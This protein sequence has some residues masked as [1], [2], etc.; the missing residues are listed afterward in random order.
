MAGLTQLGIR[1]TGR[2]RRGKVQGKRIENLDVNI[3]EIL[4]LRSRRKA[5]A[6]RRTI[7]ARRAKE[8]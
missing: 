8:E 4:R 5:S 2:C 7:W 6:I 3:T 1:K